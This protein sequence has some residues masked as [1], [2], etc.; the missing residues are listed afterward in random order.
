MAK[1]SQWILGVIIVVLVLGGGIWLAKRSAEQGREL[2]PFAQCLTER[3]AKMYGAIWCSH[4]K[5][6]K[7]AFGAAWEFV[8]Y[9]ECA[10]PGNVQAQTQ[11][12]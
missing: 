12:C 2:I 7:D 5:E 10:V 1:S 3:D 11:E 8:T 6:Q 4:C 9:V